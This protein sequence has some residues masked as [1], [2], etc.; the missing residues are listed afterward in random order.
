MPVKLGLSF[1]LTLV[2]LVGLLSWVRL[3]NQ[4]LLAAETSVVGPAA[5]KAPMFP[6]EFRIVDPDNAENN[7]K[8]ADEAKL[9]PLIV[10]FPK[11]LTHDQ[12]DAT[13]PIGRLE[14]FR[15]KSKVLPHS[16]DDPGLPV[17]LA[18]LRFL[19]KRD[20]AGKLEG[21]EIELQGEFNSVKVPAPEKAMQELLTNKRTIFALESRLQYG[22]VATHSTTKLEL[23]LSGEKLYIYSVE[24]DF[25]FRE[26]F[27]SY[28]SETLKTLP[29]SS[30]KF[31]YYGEACKLP[32]LRIL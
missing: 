11:G 13:G 31:L 14:S 1:Y 30:R 9:P 3:G 18:G 15:G 20:S 8:E 5:A 29:P 28:K 27:Y 6:L 17:L 12:K 19:E 24:G 21:Y 2:A 23:E 7:K 4:P 16:N 32:N 22:I 25:N 10:M 26:G